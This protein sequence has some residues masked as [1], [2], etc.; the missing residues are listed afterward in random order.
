MIIFFKYYFADFLENIPGPL[1]VGN[2]NE[3]TYHMND[4]IVKLQSKLES[5]N[6][7]ANNVLKK[8]NATELALSFS[9]TDTATS[10]N[11]EGK[12]L[13]ITK[14]IKDHY[15]ATPTAEMPRHCDAQ[16]WQTK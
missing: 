3:S 4:T 2:C 5:I 10:L 8:L 13:N 1:I 16:L 14:E 6:S 11:S 15:N 7:L 12:Y 9:V